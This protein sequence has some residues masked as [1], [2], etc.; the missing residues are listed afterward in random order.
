MTLVQLSMRISSEAPALVLKHAPGDDG[1]AGGTKGPAP[2]KNTLNSSVP[3]AANAL[4]LILA[5]KTLAPAS[6]YHGRCGKD[7]I[8]V[9]IAHDMAVVIA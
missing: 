8:V 4:P 7:R 2:A 9:W 3:C 6:P 5:P 1:C